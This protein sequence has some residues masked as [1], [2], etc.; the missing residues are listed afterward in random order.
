MG[1]DTARGWATG[2]YRETGA[3]RRRQCNDTALEAPDKASCAAIQCATRPGDGHDT[4]PVRATTRPS[5]RRACA[6][7][8]QWARNLGSGCAP[9]APNPVLTQCTVFSHCLGYC[10]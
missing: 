8:A 7:W 3:T 1:R 6:A 9:G 5:A 4:A 10:S 2:L